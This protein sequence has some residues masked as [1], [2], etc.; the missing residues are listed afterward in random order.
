VRKLLIVKF[1]V[2]SVYWLVLMFK[3]GTDIAGER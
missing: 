2:S 3:V 1:V